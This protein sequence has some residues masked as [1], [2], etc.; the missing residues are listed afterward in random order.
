MAVP[1]PMRCIL[2]ECPSAMSCNASGSCREA[3]RDGYL[4]YAL[5]LAECRLRGLIPRSWRHDR[6]IETETEEYWR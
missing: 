2:D 3:K 6:P 1:E 4:S 5:G